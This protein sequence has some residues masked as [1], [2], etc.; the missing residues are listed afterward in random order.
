MIGTLALI[1]GAVPIMREQGS[2][3]I[4]AVSS[5]GG[6]IAF[7]L[8]GIYQGTKFA[9]EVMVQTLAQEVAAFGVKVTLI[10]PGP[11]RTEFMSEESLKNA[12]TIAAYDGAREALAHALSP[13]LFADPWETVSPIMRVVDMPKP[14]LHLML[15]SMLPLV[16]SV[17]E[18][19][20]QCWERQLPSDG[21]VEMRR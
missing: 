10:E 21:G 18:A 3:H 20:L 4:L 19:R 12:P 1:Q 8:G 7:P 17:Y 9:V 13:D 2:G 11:F 6:L 15:G 16:R 14:P 5:V